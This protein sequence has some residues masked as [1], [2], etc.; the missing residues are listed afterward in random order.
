MD[1]IT[2][3]N[4]P[5]MPTTPL[6]SM[7]S[8]EDALCTCLLKIVKIIVGIVI[9]PL[10]LYWCYYNQESSEKKTTLATD[11]LSQPKINQLQEDFKKFF[12]HIK[13]ELVCPKPLIS[14]FV[15]RF[16][17]D[18]F[19]AF[20]A[21]KIVFQ[22]SAQEIVKVQFIDQFT[23]LVKLLKG[24]AFCISHPTL[25]NPLKNITLY[26]KRGGI[27][28]LAV[29]DREFIAKH[30]IQVVEIDEPT[31]EGALVWKEEAYL[32][33]AEQ[34]IQVVS[35]EASAKNY[36]DPLNRIIQFWQGIRVE[37]A[38]NKEYLIT[39]LCPQNL[40]L[41]KDRSIR[42]IDVQPSKTPYTISQVDSNIS[43]Y[44]R[45][46]AIKPISWADF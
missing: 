1:A 23:P 22:S 41:F 6:S 44:Q 43:R 16:Q 18:K 42:I 28:A 15:D 25:V 8:S 12:I 14:D 7:E 20:G 5:F 37:I 36:L 30:S 19:E 32:Q 39:D 17:V 40:G 31:F 3:Q 21:Y 27:D 11:L 34:I 33:S 2:I 26:L 45:A 10:G 38:Q 13:R 9:F 4:T 35:K 46:L 24:V 29:E